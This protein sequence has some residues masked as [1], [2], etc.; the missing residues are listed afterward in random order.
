MANIPPHAKRVFQGVIF[1]V[2]Q[3]EQEMFDGSTATFER[4]KRPDTVV[5]LPVAGDTIYYSRQEQPDKPL[6]LGLFGGRSDPGEEPLTAAKRELLEETGLV[7]DTWIPWKSFQ[8][9][10]KI[11]WTVYYFIAKDCRKVAEQELDGGERIEIC[12]TS[13]DD[14]MQT[15]LP[16][17]DFREGELQQQLLSSPNPNA[18]QQLK[19]LLQ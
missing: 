7:S 19:A 16:H 5:V 3:W 9:A 8:P 1:D 15:V 6:F 2:Y 4:L 17:Q 10:T 12:Q 18:I 14:F 11:D 13:L